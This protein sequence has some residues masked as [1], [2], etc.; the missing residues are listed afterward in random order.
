MTTHPSHKPATARIAWAFPAWLGIVLLIGSTL[1][2]AR[3]CSSATAVLRVSDNTTIG[4][5]RMMEEVAGVRVLYVGEDHLRKENHAAQLKVIRNLHEQGIPL[6]IGLEMFTAESQQELDRWVAGRLPP[7]DFVRLYYREWS[8]PWPL[9]RDIFLYAREHR[10]PLIGL[11]VP[12]SVTRKVARQGFA[13]LTPQERKKLPSGVT[14]S[15]DPAYRDM[16]RHAFADHA[17]DGKAFQF[18]CEAHML[19]NKSMAWHL[20]KFL[21]EKEGSTVV[22]LA[23]V[24]HAM[25]GG[26]P[27]EV[28]EMASGYS[29]RVILPELPEFPRS[30]ARSTD[31]DYLLLAKGSRR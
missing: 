7:A 4:F 25:K 5:S 6:A 24:G 20:Q 15:V 11:N 14:C 23:G 30:S 18:F 13:A 22:V 28:S 12:R 27:E 1:L 21:Q 26:I 31:V 10:I 17:H 8:M 19:W 29:Y 2:V 3:T 16:I 9:Y